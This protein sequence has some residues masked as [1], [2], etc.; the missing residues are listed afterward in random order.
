MVLSCV[1]IDPF[2]THRISEVKVMRFYRLLI[3][4]II[5][6]MDFVEVNCPVSKFT[7]RIDSNS[8]LL[9]VARNLPFEFI[10]LIYADLLKPNTTTVV[11]LDLENFTKDHFMQL[12]GHNYQHFGTILVVYKELQSVVSFKYLHTEFTI[13]SPLYRTLSP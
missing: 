9:L 7:P 4:L 10:M 6:R 2:L 12:N 8:V 1:N 5:L 3:L 11:Q 13:Q